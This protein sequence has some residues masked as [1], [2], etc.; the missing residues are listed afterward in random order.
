MNSPV[1][2]GELGRLLNLNDLLSK[3]EISLVLHPC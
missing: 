2:P 3:R 1:G